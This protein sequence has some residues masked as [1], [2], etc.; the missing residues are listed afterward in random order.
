MTRAFSLRPRC[1]KRGLPSLRYPM[2]SCSA[3]LP[4]LTRCC[5]WA[6]T[7][8]LRRGGDAP[9]TPGY[10]R[11]RPLRGRLQAQP[12]LFPSRGNGTQLLRQAVAAVPEGIPVILDGKL[13]DIANTAMHYAQFAYDRGG[14]RCRDREPLHGGRCGGALRPA[15]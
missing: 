15:W 7:H 6:S 9:P 4:R 8:R 2:Q 5:A 12:G 11:N 1:R 3:A 10:R 13:G 14:G